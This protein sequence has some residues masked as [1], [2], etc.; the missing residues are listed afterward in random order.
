MLHGHLI[1]SATDLNSHSV[2]PKPSVGLGLTVELADSSRQP[3]V[4]R[5]HRGSDGSA[6]TLWSGYMHSAAGGYISIITLFVGSVP[7]D[8]T[9]NDDGS[10]VKAWFSRF[11]W[12]SSSATIL[13]YVILLLRQ[14]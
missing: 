13:A 3:E 2:V 1:I 4:G 8:Q 10:R 6:E 11:D 5:N 14:I 12:N 7:V 9:L